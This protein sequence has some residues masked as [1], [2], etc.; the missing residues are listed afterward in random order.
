MT[1]K[2][3]AAENNRLKELNGELAEIAKKFLGYLESGTLIRDISK[4]SEPGWHL[5]MMTFVCDLK[6]FEEVISKVE[7]K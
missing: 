2:Q 3:I 5:R 4:D 6:K 1:N 7:G